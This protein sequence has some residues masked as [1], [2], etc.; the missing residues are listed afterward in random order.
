MKPKGQLELLANTGS[1]QPAPLEEQVA[2]EGEAETGE[3]S[4]LRLSRAEAAVEMAQHYEDARQLGFLLRQWSLT[5]KS[6]I[7]DSAAASQSSS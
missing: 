2:T 7:L 1:L 3:A 5:L 4:R 6:P